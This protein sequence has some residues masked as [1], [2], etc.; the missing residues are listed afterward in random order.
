MD[1][2]DNI[3]IFRHIW[4]EIVNKGNFGMFDT[5]FAPE[6]VFKNPSVTVNGPEE[7]KEYFGAILGAFS[8][9]E[10]IV[11]DAFGEG[12]KLVKRWVLHGTHTGELNGIA[13]TGRRVSLTGVTLARM[14]DGKLVEERDFA[15]DLGLLQQL[16]VIPPM[17][18]A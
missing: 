9:R 7:A 1:Q 10:F 3:E 15:D 17:E 8:D 13:P 11:E 18:E 2:P 16:G 5:H 14:V 6:Y 12:E 4:D